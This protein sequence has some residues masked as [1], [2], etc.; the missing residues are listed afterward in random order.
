MNTLKKTYQCGLF[1][2]L[3]YFCSRFAIINYSSKKEKN[4]QNFQSRRKPVAHQ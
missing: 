1:N 3:V 4:G 2:K